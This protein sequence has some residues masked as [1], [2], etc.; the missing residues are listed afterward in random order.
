MLVRAANAV[1]GQVG[2]PGP[3]PAGIAAGAGPSSSGPGAPTTPPRRPTRSAATRERE[4]LEQGLE[5][6]RTGFGARLRGAF[7]R[8]SDADWDEVEET[9][10][11]GDVGAALAMDLVERAR[12][13]R[14]VDAGD[15]GPGGARRAARAA[16]CR[17][18]GARAGRRGRPR[19][20]ARRRRQ[21]HRQDHDHRQA[22]RARARERAA[23]GP[24]RRGHVP[25]R[26]H[27]PAPDLGPAHRLRDRRPRAQRGSGRRRLRRPRRRRSR[28]APT[29]SS[30]T[31][32]GGCTRSRT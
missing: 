17:P 2:V 25:G 24:R 4:Q 27:R 30:P 18:L 32:P 11:T 19:D 20:R 14:D 28:A 8:G 31:P 13:R 7:G 16:R 15:G 6:S 3:C 29:S 10:I 1:L 9:L 5:K 26:R 22:G 21:R 23:R 12:K